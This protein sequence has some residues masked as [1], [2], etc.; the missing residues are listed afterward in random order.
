M[1]PSCDSTRL[2]PKKLRSWWITRA[3]SMFVAQTPTIASA[4]ASPKRSGLRMKVRQARPS[5]DQDD[6]AGSVAAVA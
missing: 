2:T 6:P 4:S 3:L 1:P 5:A